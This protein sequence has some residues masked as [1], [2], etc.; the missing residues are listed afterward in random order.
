MLDEQQRGIGDNGGPP[1]EELFTEPQFELIWSTA[2][3]PAMVAGFGAGKTEGLVKRC[4]RLKFQYPEQNVAYYLPTYDLVNTIAFPRFEDALAFYGLIE[5]EDFKTVKSGT[6][7]IKLIGGG[8][9]IFRTMDR[10]GRIV[11]YEVADS[12]VDE[13]DTLKEKDAAE[14]WRR[15]LSRNRQKKPDGSDNTIAVGTTP[16]GFKFVY[17]RWKKNPPT[18]EYKIIKASTYSNRRNLPDNYI[19]DLIADYPDNLILAYLEGEFVNLTSGSVYPNYDRVDNASIETVLPGEALHFGMDFNVGNMA[20]ICFVSRQHPDRKIN[21]HAVA[22]I[23]KVLDTP[24]MIKAI[25]ARFPNH[26]IFIYPDASG[27]SRKTVEASTSDLAL[28]NQAGFN[29]IANSSNPAVKDRVLAMNMMLAGCSRGKL[30]V[31]EVACPMFAE[32]LEK[33]AYN[34][35]GEPDK[36]SGLDHPNDAGGYFIST[37]FPVVDGRVV[38]TKVGGV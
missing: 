35:K 4:L 38:K 15:I 11:G 10:P 6:P 16:E 30:Y 13:L 14:V 3:F 24:A 27:G 28:L 22:E 17:D 12:F 23:M 32:A 20:A 9:I 25:K 18:D 21:P 8:N 37:R 1:L 31:N 36:T 7:M 5:G 2:R 19:D 34:D 33:Q 29:V 26:A